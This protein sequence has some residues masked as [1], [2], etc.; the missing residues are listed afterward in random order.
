MDF[1]PKLFGTLDF[2]WRTGKEHL[3]A[4]RFF[5]HDCGG[6]LKIKN[7]ALPKRDQR[8]IAIKTR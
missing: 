1:S 7:P 4:S 6:A 3:H 8:V 5:T 2:D